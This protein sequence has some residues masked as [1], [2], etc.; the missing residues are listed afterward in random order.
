MI[1]K[2]V[3]LFLLGASCLV[4]SQESPSNTDAL[5]TI[6]EQHIAANEKLEAKAKTQT[7]RESSLNDDQRYRL[8]QILKRL[9]TNQIGISHELI[10]FMSDYP[11]RRSWNSTSVEYQR[12]FGS[13]A[14]I[15]R[16]TY[17]DR[18]FT[19]GVLY[20]IDTYPVFSKKVYSNLE[21]S[22]SDGG[23]YQKFGL[24]T[25]VFVALGNGY[26]AEGG[27][28][29]LD[30]EQDAFFSTLL[31]LTKY[32]GN[33]YLNARASIGPKKEDSFI[34]NYQLTGRYYFVNAADFV[35]L[36]LGTGISPDDISRF[37]LIVNNPNLSAYYTS[38][39]FRKWFKD[40]SIGAGVG[41]LI[42]ELPNAANGTQFTANT[43]LRYRF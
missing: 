1:K 37:A 19:D 3:F 10:S 21:V 36:R 11:I 43:Q 42:E 4:Y 25:S 18:F 7:V 2:I 9:S 31:G 15:G 32:V 23:F 40:I 14:V 27:F 20:E 26:E 5:L 6:I 13:S 22:F 41:F 39:G 34:Q 30:F 24:N 16:I 38:V 28:R 17:S 8:Q 33:F 12:N 35:Y 29:Y